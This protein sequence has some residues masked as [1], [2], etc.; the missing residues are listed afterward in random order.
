MQPLM[1]EIGEESSCE[2][3]HIEGRKKPEGSAPVKWPDPD[4][5]PTCLLLKEQ[6][7]NEESAQNE[8]GIERY[9]GSGDHKERLY[10][11]NNVHVRNE[12]NEHGHASQTVETA[13]FPKAARGQ[14]RC[15]NILRTYLV[16][17]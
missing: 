11:K 1:A 16:S 13:Y 4:L 12:N 5:A 8:E 14:G 15:G 7:C 9:R 2:H 10:W 17:A 6:G 3:H